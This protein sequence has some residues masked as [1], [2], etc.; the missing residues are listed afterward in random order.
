MEEHSI[1]DLKWRSALEYRSIGT[2][3][4]FKTSNGRMKEETVGYDIVHT[5]DAGDL[6]LSEWC[7][8]MERAVKREGK[9]DLLTRIVDYCRRLAWLHSEKEVRQHALEC[10]SSG[11]YRAWKDF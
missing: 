2:G 8:Q 5:V 10:L 11:A 4:F 9:E 7:Q 3:R 6:E 1:D